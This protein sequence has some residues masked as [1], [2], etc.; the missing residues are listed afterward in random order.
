MHKIIELQYLYT[1]NPLSN[2]LGGL[3]SPST[4]E[5]VLIERGAY[6]SEMHQQQQGFLRRDLWL[7]GTILF[8]KQ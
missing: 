2:P 3:F 8:F 5:G 6:F 4:F 7:P 1:V